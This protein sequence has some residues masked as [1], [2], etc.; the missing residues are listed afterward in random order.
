MMDVKKIEPLAM[1]TTPQQ[2]RMGLDLGK[3]KK[4]E[5]S[6]RRKSE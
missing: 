4:L 3:G 5:E 2:V 1:Q 6:Q